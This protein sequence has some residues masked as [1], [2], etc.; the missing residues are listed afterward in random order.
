[1]PGYTIQLRACKYILGCCVIISDEPVFEDLGLHA[2]KHR[3]DFRRLKWY[4]KV[5]HMNSNWLPI[6]L[7]LNK[8]DKKK[9]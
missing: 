9:C 1:M 5:M 3:R 6:K 4:H 8:W 7:L 2:L